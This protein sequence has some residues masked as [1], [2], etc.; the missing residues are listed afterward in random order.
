M[1]PAEEER[2]MSSSQA[3][4][5]RLMN[6]KA[7]DIGTNSYVVSRKQTGEIRNLSG[8]G[9]LKPEQMSTGSSKH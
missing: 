5:Q 6:K 1:I 3:T 7:S 9:I 8:K 4:A 2:P